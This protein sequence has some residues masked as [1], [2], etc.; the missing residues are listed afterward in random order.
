MLLNYLYDTFLEE[1]A[2]AK[3]AQMSLPQ[4]QGF[5]ERGICPDASY[6]IQ[7]D[8]ASTSFIATHL[9]HKTYRFHL[10]GH[11]RWIETLSSLGIETE[12]HAQQH[13]FARYDEAKRQFLSGSLG[14]ALRE[15]APNVSAKFTSKYATDTWG[16][17]KQG[18]YGLCTRGG[19][20][21]GIFVKQACVLFIEEM[22]AT[23]PDAMSNAQ[24]EVLATTVDHLDKVESDFAPHEVSQSSRQRCITDVKSRYLTH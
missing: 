24:I 10:K 1:A 20:P 19:Q 6:S 13:F 11:I 21:E 14:E 15:Y 9:D 2:F 23:P 3:A 18:V 17:F 4:L 16:Y 22:I 7:T 8:T 5:I 12:A